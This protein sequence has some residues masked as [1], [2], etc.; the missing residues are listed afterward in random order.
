MTD[1]EKFLKYWNDFI[2]ILRQ[3][4]TKDETHYFSYGYLKMVLAEEAISWSSESE[5][6][7]RWL[8][9]YTKK[10]PDQGKR[11]LNILTKDM[12]FSPVEKPNKDYASMIRSAA[13]VIGA[14]AGLSI[15]HLLH[16]PNLWIQFFSI[17]APAVA[18]YPAG[19]LISDEIAERTNLQWIKTYLDQLEKYKNS[20]LSILSS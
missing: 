19:M 14:A 17:V 20:V 1:S 12:R 15:V 10:H 16:I 11:I 3:K 8:A 4:I 6:N 5:V 2:Q 18:A 13:P 7:G 9:E